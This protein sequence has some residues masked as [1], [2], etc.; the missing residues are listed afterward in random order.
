MATAVLC[1]PSP[2]ARS[3]LPNWWKSKASFPAPYL[4]RAHWVALESWQALPAPELK[5]LLREARDRVEAKM[6]KRIRETLALPADERKKL[7]AAKKK[8][9][10]KK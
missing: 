6:P 5:E 1:S 9:A 4:A 10:K 8:E 2:P 7:I 3:A